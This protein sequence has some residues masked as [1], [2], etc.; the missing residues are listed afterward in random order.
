MPD[1]ISKPN[2]SMPDLVLQGCGSMD[3]AIQFCADN[4]VSL[5][6]YPV[7]GNSYQVSGQASLLG[8]GSVLS[9]LDLNGITIGTL[10]TV[11]D[12]GF[13]VVLKPV[14][15]V[16][17]TDPDPPA[18]S[19]YYGFNMQASSAFINSLAI[20]SGDFPSSPNV[21]LFETEDRIIAGFA[22]DTA[23]QNAPTLVMSALSIPYKI[24]W[25]IGR[26]FMMLWSDLGATAKTCTITDVNGNTAF[27]SPLIVLDNLTQTV[28]E[29]LV[30]DLSVE[31]VSAGPSVV[32]LRLT[33]SHRSVAHADFVTH[34]MTWLNDAAGGS[35]D[36][37]DPSNPDK[38]IVVL[39]EG[40]YTFGVA[41]VYWNTTYEYP[42]SAF[43]MVVVVS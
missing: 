18:V 1:L 35:S 20:A 11:P 3:A 13:A 29:Y 5:T 34:V 17:P 8:A 28:E 39:S 14:M 21:L 33:R 4:N 23:A 41:T 7:T 32:T 31:L 12:L 26:G 9:Y 37:L 10:G 24:P 40:T 36:P 27:V 30:A 6:D 16:V 43:T 2:Q 38:T 19:G 25:I 15:E 42:A 22:P